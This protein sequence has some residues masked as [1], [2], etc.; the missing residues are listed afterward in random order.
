MLAKLRPR[1]TYANVMATVA[2]FVALSTGGAYAANTVFSTDIVDGEVKTADIA[3]QAVNS[4]KIG[5]GGVQNADLS[6][7]AVTAPK[8]ADGAV[9]S[10]KVADGGIQG[11]DVT[12]N[13]LTGAQIDEST[14]F[15]DN[16]LTGDDISNSSTLGGP[17]ISESTLGTVPSALA[18]GDQ[19]LR[20]INTHADNGSGVSS[21]GSIGATS[22][23]NL[24]ISCPVSTGDLT[25]T[26]STDVDNASLAVSDNDSYFDV[27]DFDV[28]TGDV[29]ILTPLGANSDEIIYFVY[30]DG[31]GF[32]AHKVVSG[33][34][35]VLDEAPPGTQS[36]CLV[37]GHAIFT[38]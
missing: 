22:G 32:G 17:E 8:I 12:S 28:A 33:Q 27:E 10:A 11:V 13:T 7:N 15:N 14:L 9:D 5:N 35:H 24:R 23:L 4:P 38:R 18:V 3:N 30:V 31:S 20:R 19:S 1:L 2:V 6:A 16:S 36:E 37:A 29:D 26:L 21:T 25:L 34:F